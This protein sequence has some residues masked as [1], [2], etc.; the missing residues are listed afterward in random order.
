MKKVAVLLSSYNGEKYIK[1]QVDSILN[2]TYKNIEIYIRDDGSKDNTL[3][4]LNEYSK[5]ANIHII[6]GKNV[7]F[8]KSF[9][10]LLKECDSADFYAFCDQDDVWLE[11]KIEKA[12]NKLD[13]SK[14]K[15][16]I[17]DYDY[18]DENMQFQSHSQFYKKTKIP[19]FEKSLIECIAPGMTMVFNKKL[20]DIIIK[21]IPSKCC[22]HDWWVY[23]VATSFG[24]VIYDSA[25]TVKYR[26]H[27]KNV[28]EEANGVLKNLIK[29]I[30]NKKFSNIWGKL[31]EQLIEFEKIYGTSLDE[32]QKKELQLFTRRKFSFINYFKKI[33]FKKRFKD[34]IKDEVMIRIMFILN[35]I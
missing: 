31:K 4:I 32:I 23:Q 3:K 28:S 5:R 13:D 24:E 25:V 26:R 12:I 17:S 2:Q 14:P 33:F 18:Y 8:I 19:S 22:Y 7:G 35:R 34:N 1:E 11:N 30:K 20:R 15:L 27:S 16:Y 10:E 9:F 21:Q 29:V 6:P